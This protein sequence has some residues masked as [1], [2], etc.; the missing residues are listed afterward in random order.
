[1]GELKS[2]EEHSMEMESNS[3]REQECSSEEESSSEDQESSSEDQESSS[4]DKESSS[5][6]KESSSEDKESSSEDKESSSEEEGGAKEEGGAED[7]TERRRSMRNADKEEI[8]FSLQEMG[9]ENF[10]QFKYYLD[11]GILK[12]GKKPV[13]QA[14]HLDDNVMDWDIAKRIWLG[15]EVSAE[16]WLK[17]GYVIDLPLSEEGSWLRVAIPNLKKKT[18]DMD[19]VFI[20]YGSFLIRSVAL[21]HSGHYGSPGN[22]RFHATFSV[23]DT[24]LHTSNLTYFRGMGGI[25][26]FENW[27][28]RWNPH[29]PKTCRGP[30]GYTRYTNKHIRSHKR[31]GTMYFN[32][33]IEPLGNIYYP[34]ILKN[35]SI[36]KEI[37]VPVVK[38]ERRSGEASDSSSG[39]TSNES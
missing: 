7:T 22:T 9:V 21:F 12:Q 15:E 37:P 28:L 38:K 14:L 33:A 10:Q 3:D 26:E 13:H 2:N 34:D 17:C 11:T 16:E 18:F 23:Q 30:D 1:L 4:E 32:Q 29:V 19:W 5:E 36:Y 8:N 25:P 6:D 31:R 35:L 27:K 24:S 39:G 20:P